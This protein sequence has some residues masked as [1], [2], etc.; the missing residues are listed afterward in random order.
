MMKKLLASIALLALAACQSPRHYSY[1]TPP[2][3]PPPYPSGMQP[4]NGGSPSQPS[5]PPRV[6]PSMPNYNG[7]AGALTAKNVGGYMDGLERDLR[8]YL[9]GI[10]VARPGDVVVLNLKSDDLFEK[11]NLTDDGRDLLRNLSSALKHYDRTQVQVN[12]YTD[13][14]A[15]PEKALAVTQKR[16]DAVA[17]E[18]HADGIAGGRLTATGYGSAHLRIATGDGKAEARNRRIEIRIVP[19]PG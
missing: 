5:P 10:P 9:R 11:S 15:A 14:R 8:H 4:Y 1:V 6:K 13:T 16:A 17:A 7:T 12:G 18:L 2:P 19:K 3:P